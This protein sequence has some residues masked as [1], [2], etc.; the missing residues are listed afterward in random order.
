MLTKP[1]KAKNNK[2]RLTLLVSPV[3]EQNPFNKGD[4]LVKQQITEP[5]AIEEKSET[6]EKGKVM[7]LSTITSELASFIMFIAIGS[8]NSSVLPTK[9]T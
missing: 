8:H 3:R 2:Y 1:D 5:F 4:L 9:P 7:A 6:S